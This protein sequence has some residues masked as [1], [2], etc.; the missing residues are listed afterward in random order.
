MVH[1]ALT[2][3]FAMPNRADLMSLS[4]I[5][6]KK[7][8]VNTSTYDRFSTIRNTSSN[9]ATSDIDGKSL[10]QKTDDFTVTRFRCDFQ[11]SWL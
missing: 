3:D 6:K 2:G 11:A 8:Q 10:K 9:L 5:S 7:D 1:M 4:T